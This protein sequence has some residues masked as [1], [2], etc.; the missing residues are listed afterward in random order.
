L[1]KTLF[2]LVSLALP[3][4]YSYLVHKRNTYLE[5][6][7]I[8][9][10]KVSPYTWAYIGTYFQKNEGMYILYVTED[11]AMSTGHDYIGDSV[12]LPQEV[13]EEVNRVLTDGGWNGGNY[14]Y[15]RLMVVAQILDNNGIRGFYRHQFER[16]SNSCL[17]PMQMAFSHIYDY[18]GLTEQSKEKISQYA[19]LFTDT[20]TTQ[21]LTT[22]KR[23]EDIK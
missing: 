13:Y 8:D 1:S 18:N 3:F 17:S 22:T 5:S 19:N 14:N 21:S 10:I 6:Q 23:R 15:E 9:R 11:D 7:K 4:L 2:V 20:D 12:E 16:I